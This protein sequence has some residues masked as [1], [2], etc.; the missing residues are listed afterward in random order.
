M[1]L[2]RYG[3]QYA[4]I[5]VEPFAYPALIRKFRSAAA[6]RK[7]RE[8]RDLDFMIDHSGHL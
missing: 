1:A 6:A 2:L 4:G 5:A 3:T 7:E 8:S